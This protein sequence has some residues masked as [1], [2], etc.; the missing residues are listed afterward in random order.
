M[1]QEFSGYVMQLDYALERIEA[2]LSGLYQ[3]PLGGTAV[4]TGLNS[5]PDYAVKVAKVLAE[6]TK[7]NFITAPNKFE[8]LAA[9]D[10]EVFAEV[11]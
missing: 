1:G 10:A 11:H 6:L 5:H 4:G 7:L 2:A 3:L 9:R 8:A